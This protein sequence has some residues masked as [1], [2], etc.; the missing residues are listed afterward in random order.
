MLKGY[1]TNIYGGALL[2]PC[3]Q[4]ASFTWNWQELLVVFPNMLDHKFNS[5]KCAEN[6][7]T[8]QAR[9]VS[10][11][12]FHGGFI[13]TLQKQRFPCLR[14]FD[15]K[16]SIRGFWIKKKLLLNL[17]ISHN[18][19]SLFQWISVTILNNVYFELVAFLN[20]DYMQNRAVTGNYLN[21]TALHPRC[22]DMGI[23]RTSNHYGKVSVWSHHVALLTG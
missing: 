2:G 12:Q 5:E 19:H 13:L 23:T 11:S 16:A 20:I 18:F 15:L 6:V 22:T 9:T 14:I 3:L 10:F 1:D 17:D 4:T 8:N 7:V 21:S